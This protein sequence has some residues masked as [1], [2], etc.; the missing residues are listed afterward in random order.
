[1]SDRQTRLAMRDM[2][3]RAKDSNRLIAVVT[4]NAKSVGQPH[5][6]Q[7]AID[8]PP[9]L[10]AVFPATST[11]VVNAEKSLFCLT[12][13]GTFPTIMSQDLVTN[14]VAI[15]LAGL[16]MLFSVGRD[17]SHR[18]FMASAF[19]LFCQARPSRSVCLSVLLSVFC[20]ALRIVIDNFSVLACM[21]A[22]VTASAHPSGHMGLGRMAFGRAS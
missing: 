11:D 8:G 19:L 14:P 2:R 7:P 12:A 20:A 18:R 3:A 16:T 17:P 21:R 15:V 5:R 1:M 6:S 22:F 4:E 10:H 13:A 9:D